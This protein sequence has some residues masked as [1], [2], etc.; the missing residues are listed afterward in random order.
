[1]T[2]RKMHALI[3]LRADSHLVNQMNSP[4]F[5]TPEMIL[6]SYLQSQRPCLGAHHEIQRK[7]GANVSRRL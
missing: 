4:Y 2:A 1:M 6:T 7:L 3:L 5:V